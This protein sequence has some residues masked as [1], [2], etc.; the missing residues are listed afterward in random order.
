MVVF[1][2]F[3]HADKILIIGCPY[4]YIIIALASCYDNYQCIQSF[5]IHLIIAAKFL[6]Y[7]DCEQGHRSY[8]FHQNGI[9]YHKYTGYKEFTLFSMKNSKFETASSYS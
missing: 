8:S 2:N 6:T 7:K 9:C 1:P 5:D 4:S 3:N